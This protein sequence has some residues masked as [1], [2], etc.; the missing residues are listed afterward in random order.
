MPNNDARR[1][2]QAGAPIPR[3]MRPTGVPSVSLWTRSL[4]QALQPL[5]CGLPRWSFI[6]V[7]YLVRVEYRTTRSDGASECTHRVPYP[8]CRTANHKQ[9]FSCPTCIVH[10][11]TL[12]RAGFVL[13]AR[14]LFVVDR[15]QEIICRWTGVF[16]T[17]FF[18]YSS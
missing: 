4:R 5:L 11:A 16:Y 2:Q 1:D 9:R 18:V 17:A 14:N 6:G 12:A 3:F 15:N 7:A 13:P 8:Y 10:I